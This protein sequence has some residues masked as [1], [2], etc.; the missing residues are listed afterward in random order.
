MKEEIKKKG[1]KMKFFE[2]LFG[3]YTIKVKANTKEEAKKKILNKFYSY[4]EGSRK[5]EYIKQFIFKDFTI[6][7]VIERNGFYIPKE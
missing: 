1:G 3:Q 5:K 6:I 2:G 4:K 7:E